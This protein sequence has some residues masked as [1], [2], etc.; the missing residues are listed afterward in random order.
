MKWYIWPCKML[1]LAVA[2]FAW[3]LVFAAFWGVVKA[4]V[5]GV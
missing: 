5:L 4:I 3:L 1:L 2:L